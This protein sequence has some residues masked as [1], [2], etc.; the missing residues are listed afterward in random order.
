MTNQVNNLSLIPSTD[1]IQIN[2]T[3]TM[4]TAQVVETSVTLNNNSPI[5]DYFPVYPD[6]HVWP[7]YEIRYWI[8][9]ALQD[10]PLNGQ[11]LERSSLV[12][13]RIL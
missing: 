1:M 6:N 9:R 11:E 3:L 12:L 5:E 4:T 7:T 13:Y 2:W 10:R 8:V